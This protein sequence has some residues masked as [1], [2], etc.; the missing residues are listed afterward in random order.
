MNDDLKLKLERMRGKELEYT[1]FEPLSR[2]EARRGEVE[3]EED[4]G[5]RGKLWGHRWIEEGV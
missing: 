3:E 5:V 2:G 1:A 4:Y